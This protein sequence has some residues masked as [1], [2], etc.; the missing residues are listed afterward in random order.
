MAGII[1][2]HKSLF[3][4]PSAAVK[5]DVMGIYLAVVSWLLGSYSSS[6]KLLD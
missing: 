5:V 4:E 2:F 1:E 3:P 6:N